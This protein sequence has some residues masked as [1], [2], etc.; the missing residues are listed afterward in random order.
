MN[1]ILALFEQPTLVKAVYETNNFG[2][3]NGLNGG[4]A[5]GGATQFCS[6]HCEPANNSEWR[7]AA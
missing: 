5:L 4:N 7:N 2:R 3:F 1:A 6:H